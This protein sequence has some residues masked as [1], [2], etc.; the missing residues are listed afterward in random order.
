M[1]AITV[2]TLSNAAEFAS[3]ESA[4]KSF[5]LKFKYLGSAVAPALWLVFSLRHMG[6]GKRLTRRNLAL[7]GL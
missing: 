2:W 7:L 5:W 4:A 3:V 1:V 6:E